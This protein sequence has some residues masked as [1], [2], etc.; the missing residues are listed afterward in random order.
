M[1]T[2]FFKVDLRIRRPAFR[3]GSTRR[4]RDGSRGAGRG[5]TVLGLGRTSRMESAWVG[6]YGRP[7][8]PSTRTG[9]RWRELRFLY[10]RRSP[11]RILRIVRE[12]GA[13]VMPSRPACVAILL[14][15]V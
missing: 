13:N 5:P 2:R 10:V 6:G 3:R 4:A 9:R 11:A 14:F 1:I 15:W 12:G 7:R 8:E